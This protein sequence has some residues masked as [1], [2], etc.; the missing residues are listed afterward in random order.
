MYDPYLYENSDVLVNKLNIR[1]KSELDL[2]ERNVTAAKLMQIGN[3]DGN[4]DFEHLKRMHRFIFGDIYEWAGK[5][6]EIPIE[7]R[8]EVLGGLSVQYAYPNEIKF[9]VDKAISELHKTDWNNLSLSDKS[10]KFAVVTAALWQVHAFREGNTRTTIAFACE[11]AKVHGFPM[12]K[13]LFAE[14]SDYTRKALVMASIGKYSEY[15]HLSKI[16]KDSMERGAEMQK[17]LDAEV[18][19]EPKTDSVSAPYYIKVESMEQIEK[20]KQANITL[21][22]K[23]TNDGRLIIRINKS[24]ANN[25]REILN[26]SKKNNR[27][28]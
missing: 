10:E 18:E 11:F 16:F 21:E 6:R 13:Q 8:E 17:Q 28:I 24:D 19:R 22:S 15:Q 7:K 5:E 25:V 14:Y 1:N 26:K 12:D 23:E 9:E 3:I 2:I 27:T 4:F 20:L